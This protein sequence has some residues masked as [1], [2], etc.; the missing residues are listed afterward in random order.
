MVLVNKL[1]FESKLIKMNIVITGAS[2]G[3]GY[4]LCKAFIE[5]SE[6]NVFAVARNGKKLSALASEINQPD[7]F[8]YLA[9]DLQTNDYKKQLLPEIKAKLNRID[10]LINNAGAILHKPFQEINDEDF[11]LVFNMN[12]KSPFRMIRDLLPL[13]KAPSHIINI[14][15]MGGV[16]GSVKFPGLSLY[17]ASKGALSVLTECLALEF[18]DR[19][20]SVNALAIGAVQTEMLEEAFPGYQAPLQPHQ[21]AS[22][23]KEFASTGHQYFNGKILPV[24]LSTP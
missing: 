6:N 5:N 10:V 2:R 14:S 19:Q 4:E 17:S 7:R 13:F 11:D 1:N 18:K 23:I 20:I 16:Q 12:V 22:F 3:I 8:H 21:M 15:S 24:A 9:F